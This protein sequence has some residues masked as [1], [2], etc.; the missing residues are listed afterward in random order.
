M[1]FFLLTICFSC[2]F[3]HAFF[4]FPCIVFSHFR[5]V[6]DAEIFRA[7]LCVCV[8]EL[9]VCLC[10]CYVFLMSP[11]AGNRF[12]TAT[13]HMQHTYV[14]CVCVCNLFHLND[15]FILLIAFCKLLL[16]RSV[17]ART[18]LLLRPAQPSPVLA[19]PV[20]PC[21]ALPCPVAIFV[22]LWPGCSTLCFVFSVVVAMFVCRFSYCC[23][24]CA[25]CCC[26]CC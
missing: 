2:G 17:L 8:R 11:V 23:C 5:F 25:Y 6:A 13:G 7:A 18:P 3:F 20:L 14:L 26:C 15:L 24:S 19:S 1:I 9:F 4:A 21:P 12:H 16:L 22:E 10:V